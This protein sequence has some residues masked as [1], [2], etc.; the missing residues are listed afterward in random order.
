MLCAFSLWKTITSGNFGEFERKLRGELTG[1]MRFD[2]TGFSGR[3]AWPTW[4]MRGELLPI[5]IFSV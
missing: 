3:Q 1:M 2:L 4:V 5:R